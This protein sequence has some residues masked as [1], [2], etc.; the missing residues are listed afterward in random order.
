MVP[1]TTHQQ[2]RAWC[3]APPKRQRG[4]PIMY[5]IL[6]R[7][8]AAG[9]TLDPDKCWPW[10]GAVSPDGYGRIAA[11]P[12]HETRVHRVAFREWVGPIPDGHDVHHT[13]AGGHAACEPGE[14]CDHR[15]CTNPSHLAAAA[16]EE[17]YVRRRRDERGLLC[18]SGRHPFKPLRSGRRECRAC[19]NERQRAVNAARRAAGLVR[20]R[21]PGFPGRTVQRGAGRDTATGR[22]WEVWVDGA[23]VGTVER[24]REELCTVW[25]ANGTPV[26]GGGRRAAYAAA[27]ALAGRVSR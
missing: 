25:A 19:V 8:L 9:I 6:R 16:E 2:I 14:V 3:A 27:V 17:G 4:E 10:P 11:D 24:R 23:L 26:P 21:V 18:E 20:T 15:A 1:A 13:P 12:G 7:Y 22:A 5:R